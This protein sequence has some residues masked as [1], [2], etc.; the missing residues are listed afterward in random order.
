MSMQ[1]PQ[2]R[3][4][5]SLNSTPPATPHLRLAAN[6]TGPRC[7]E[8]SI[9]DGLFLSLG[10]VSVVENVLVVAAIAK[11]RN[12][13]SP[14]YYF[15]CCLAV[16]DLLV[17]VSNV[18]ETTVMLLLEAGA[19]ATRAAVVQQLDDI[20]DV[21]ICGA[22]VSSLCFLGAIAV[23]RYISIFYALRYHNIVTLPRA[24]RA[25][26]TIWVASVLSSTLFIAYYNHTAVLLCLVSFFVA[27][28]V[29]M[30]VLYVHML[31]RA[32]QHARGIAR[33]HKRQRPAHQSFGLKGAATL[34]TLLGVFFLCWGPFFLHL[35][36]MVL[37]PQHPICGCVFKNFKLFLTLIICN[38]I[39][40][41]LIYAFR[42]QELRKTLQE[43]MLCSW[44]GDL[45]LESQCGEHDKYCSPGG[46]QEKG[47][48]DQQGLAPH[49]RFRKRMFWE[50]ISDEHGID[51]SGN[52]VGDSD[53]QLERI[54][55]YY[56]EASSHKYVPRAIL[57]DLEP[58]TMDSVRSGA[59][60]HLFR[61]DN[62]IFGQSGAGNNWAK[63][64]YTEGAELVDSVL[65]VVRKECENCDC[66]QGFQLTHSLGGG[67]GSGMGTLLISKVRE[68]YPDRIMNT[69]SVVPSPKVSD[70][71]VEPYNA[72][73]S[74][75]QL[76]ENT[77]E[78][79]CIDNE[80][81]YD[82]CFRTLKLATPT[83]GDLNHL[84][85]ATMSGVTT[86][87]RFPGQLNADLRKLAVNMV[88]FPRLHFFMPG[89]APLTDEQMLNVQNKNSSY[90]VEWIPNN[91]KVAVCDIPPRGLKMSSTF[92][93][94]STAIQELFKRIS[95]QFTAMFRRKAFLHWYTGE[96]MDE[97]EFTEAES[98][99]ND[100][101]SEYQQYQDAT[102]EE[103]GE[104]YEDDEEESEAQG[105]K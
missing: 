22:M 23:D 102:A 70:T 66:L 60:G 28:L 51:P 39:V 42:S 1:G 63:G 74:I 67:T 95:E 7:L 5:G 24:W 13:H 8:V 93:G 83:Y 37:C 6:Q 27:M 78:T 19:M 54:S 17:S 89:F 15:I 18:L 85:S 98:N 16:S 71:V 68:E 96:G 64:H 90:F 55:V 104:M 12:L 53:L 84:V 87:L 97:M 30:A 38:S 82:I 21:L 80:A 45:S 75:H 86:S 88:P 76:V 79:Y 10:L 100:L 25:I 94:N 41:P 92:I 69:F 77:D 29:L 59:F 57:V 14:M 47:L 49:D 11:N 56:N 20:I 33:L 72:T 62:F 9:P 103:E 44:S 35:S 4:L 3:L 2:R 91:V 32:C 105:P 46:P 61:P 40:D 26:S 65:D 34:T 52:Y 81:L 50:V 31:A 101:V 99:M 58:G 73:L 43:V 36:L 48:C